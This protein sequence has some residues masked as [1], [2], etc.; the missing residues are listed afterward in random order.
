MARIK[1]TQVR[2]TIKR[3][4]NQ[5]ATMEALGLRGIGKTTEKELTP[6]IQGMVRTIQHLVSVEEL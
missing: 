2:S 5:K 6:Q 3:P 4:K 1:I